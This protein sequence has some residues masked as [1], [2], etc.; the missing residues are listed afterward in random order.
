MAKLDPAGEFG[1]IETTDGRQIYFHRNSVLNGGFARLDLGA[2][3]VYVEE[4]GEK[5]PQAS[6]VK[7]LKKH[8]L[9]L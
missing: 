2:R 8:A 1:F 9:K 3:V 6:T 7:P 4:A 5:S